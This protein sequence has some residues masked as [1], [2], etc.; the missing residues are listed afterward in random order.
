[1]GDDECFVIERYD[2]TKLAGSVKEDTEFVEIVVGS[3]SFR[4][5]KSKLA[6]RSKYFSILFQYTN[7]EPVYRLNEELF[8]VQYMPDLMKYFE[9]RKLDFLN[10]ENVHSILISADYLQIKTLSSE[11]QRRLCYYVNE[12]NCISL[13]TFSMVYS[14]ESLKLRCITF[15]HENFQQI[16]ANGKILGLD[17]EYFKHLVCCLESKPNMDGLNE[18]IF[19]LIICWIEHDTVAR[20]PLLPSLL[21]NYRFDHS[22]KEFLETQVLSNPFVQSFPEISHQIEELFRE[23]S[24]KKM[25]FVSLK[26]KFYCERYFFIH[27]LDEQHNN[28][29]I[30][31]TIGPLRFVCK[32]IK[33][34][35]RYQNK[36][37]IAYLNEHS[38]VVILEFDCHRHTWK[39][40]TY[41]ANP[42]VFGSMAILEDYIYILYRSKL[43]HSYIARFNLTC[44]RWYTFHMPCQDGTILLVRNNSLITCLFPLEISSSILR[45]YELSAVQCTIGDQS[46]CSIGKK[47]FKYDF[48]AQIWTRLCEDRFGKIDTSSNIFC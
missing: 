1:M 37:Y 24:D 18:R 21:L 15:I 45:I 25:Y 20:L 46:Y 44:Q 12:E 47:M 32:A 36:L 43:E 40:L 4:A 2:P 9:N 17:D 8:E 11:C 5:N 10:S 29:S 16:I 42:M 26:S 31:T 27:R 35:I 48:S 14:L 30:V 39:E 13:Y 38:W 6:R 22:S 34:A 19:F 23:S 7:H 41:F 33:A 3:K 28:H